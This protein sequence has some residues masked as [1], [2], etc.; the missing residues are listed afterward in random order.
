[1]NSNQLP[2]PEQVS[3]NQEMKTAAGLGKLAFFVG[4]G[5]SRLYSIP[6][7]D[8]LSNRMLKALAQNN[9]VDHNK[10]EL[11]SKQSLKARISI[12]DH[13]FKTIKD[14]ASK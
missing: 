5:I 7:W 9:I 6:S 3:I 14:S 1:M 13:Y 10:V 2:P 12:A 8:E 11:L 4:N